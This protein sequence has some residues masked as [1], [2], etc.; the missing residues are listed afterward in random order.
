MNIE[1][2]IIRDGYDRKTC[3][4]HPRCGIIPAQ[5]GSSPVGVMTMWKT[6]LTGNDTFSETSDLRTED[7]GKTWDGPT[8][9]KNLW[10]RPLSEGWD[11]GACDWTPRW[12]AASGK[13]INI[14]H[15]VVYHNDEVA[16]SERKTVYSV[17][18]PTSRIWSS[19]KKLAFPESLREKFYNE[20]AG[21]VQ[22]VELGN[23]QLLIPTYFA[24][25]SPGGDPFE[26]DY[27]V[28]VL[29]CSFDGETLRYIDHGDELRAPA[30]S[31]RG[32]SEPSICEVNGR[33]YLTLRND[34]S[35][36]VAVGDD[37]L[38]FSPPKNW[39]WDDG[40]EL[41][42]Y[43]TQ[44]HFL[45]HEGGLHLVYTRRGADNDHVFRHRA[46]LFIAEVNQES[47]R[48]VRDSEQILAPNRGAR[49]GN[50]GV[51]KYGE[52]EYWITV[53]E[54][55]QAAGPEPICF[56]S[57]ICEKYGSNNAIYLVRVRF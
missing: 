46:P 31:G 53:A 25:D 2:Q 37:G 32:F 27:A 7:G 36:C 26:R 55:M 51:T 5:N 13:L 33:F 14:G 56:D 48:I 44:Q 49:L 20:G 23:G 28:T 29:R 12:H 19:F 34:N 11:E 38:H 39:C 57:T 30:D 9:Q 15:S 41:G 43:N 50:F 52:N 40:G 6:R 10:R 42:S 54:W 3:W 1:N 8:P 16:L 35:A 24:I 45:V 4:V 17:Y 21:C 18:D 47:L 22:S